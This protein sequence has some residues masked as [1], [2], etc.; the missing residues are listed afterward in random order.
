M[1]K[2]YETSD[3]MKV[4]LSIVESFSAYRDEAA[5]IYAE[6]GRTTQYQTG[7]ERLDDYL[8]GGFGSANRGELVVLVADTGVGKST[9]ASNIAIRTTGNSGERCHYMSLENPPEDAYNTMCH[10]L[11]VSTLGATEA[12]FTAPSKE[13]L[14]GGKPWTADDLL[15]HMTYVVKSRH[16]KIFVLDHLN[17]MFEN[18]DQV[19]N[20]LARTRVVMRLLSQW[21]M[22]NKATVFVISHINKPA[23]K[24]KKNELLTL[25]RIYGSGGIAGA[26]TKVIALNEYIDEGVRYI[27]VQM[28][29]SRYTDWDRNALCRFDVSSYAW[30]WEGL[31]YR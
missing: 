15:A 1:G 30:K 13:L 26:A 4:D 11:G 23:G 27:D 18:E 20:E 31:V 8:G 17:F 19:K 21:C 29:K 12:Y 6:N 28:L 10:I 9:F 14:F 3:D 5:K 7:W 25:S 22:Q 2:A 24:A 16:T